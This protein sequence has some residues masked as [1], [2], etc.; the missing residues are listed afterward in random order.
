[1]GGIMIAALLVGFTFMINAMASMQEARAVAGPNA[2]D[3]M[4]AMIAAFGT[5][6]IVGPIVVSYVIGPDSDFSQSLL[7]AS[8]VLIVSAYFLSRRTGRKKSKMARA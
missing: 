6:Q 1:I 2:T 8:M 4:A 5:G 7:L 3:L